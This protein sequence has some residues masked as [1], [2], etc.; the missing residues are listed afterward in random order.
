[1]PERVTRMERSRT[2]KVLIALFVA[3]IL[4]SVVLIVLETAPVNPHRDLAAISHPSDAL[5]RSIYR[6]NV[7]VQPVKWRSIVIH[8]TGGR[9]ANIAK[10]SH[11][12]VRPD[13]E[14]SSAVE[15]TPLWDRQVEG[16]HVY[17]PGRDFNSDSIG[18]CLVGDFS[19]QPPSPSQMK[20]LLALVQSLQ[21]TLNVSAD[22]VY[23]HSDL[24]ASSRSPGAAFPVREFTLA[25]LRV[26]R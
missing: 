8:S 17:V 12:L 1:M 15:M 5:G 4:G 19:A 18:V 7:P 10:E 14:G 21:R 22:H 6:T 2:V 16:N 23:L 11:F 20:A 9:G 3:M 25:L 26:E 13:G 24:D